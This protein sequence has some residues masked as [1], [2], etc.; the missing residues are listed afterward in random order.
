MGDMSVRTLPFGAAILMLFNTASVNAEE[1]ASIEAKQDDNKEEQQE[2]TS[3]NEDKYNV[4]LSGGYSQERMSE[5]ATDREATYVPISELG[6]NL[7]LGKR[8]D[9][10]FRF[11]SGMTDFPGFTDS[12]SRIDM[13]ALTIKNNGSVGFLSDN[14]NFK[15]GLLGD[16]RVLEASMD[17][18]YSGGRSPILAGQSI[19]NERLQNF[20]GASLSLNIPF[21]KDWSWSFEGTAGR[22]QNGTGQL[23]VSDVINFVANN[24]V[25]AAPVLRRDMHVITDSIFDSLDNSGALDFLEGEDIE[26]NYDVSLPGAGQY[27]AAAVLRD[28]GDSEILDLI[29]DAGID[30]EGLLATELQ[31]AIDNTTITGTVPVQVANDLVHTYLA[32]SRINMH[33]RIDTLSDE[34]IMDEFAS[35]AQYIRALE[36]LLGTYIGGEEFL[37]AI[38]YLGGNIDN[39]D[40]RILGNATHFLRESRGDANRPSVMLKTSFNRNTD[41]SSLSFGV[42]GGRISAGARGT[43]DER[44]VSIFAK[45]S[46]N[47]GS[48][49]K[50]RGSFSAVGYDGYLNLTRDFEKEKSLQTGMATTFGALEWNPKFLDRKLT[51][52][53]GI[54]ASYNYY[55]GIAKHKEIGMQYSILDK[56]KI[57][58]DV[59]GGYGV[60]KYEESYLKPESGKVNAIQAGIL[61]NIKL[62]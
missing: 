42:E 34:R 40:I 36:P 5:P 54:G 47:I 45:G 17:G 35:S 60:S 57:S 8:F 37:G 13:A 50:L 30:V 22:T 55:L 10:D 26:V 11:N 41:R 31:T 28:A 6:V 38:A 39:F 32:Q 25:Y 2:S 48:S 3:S 16:V 15:L 33:A 43:I 53:A 61:F 59:F 12:K 21:T 62:D 44:Y 20:A 52:N 29:I 4:T 49:F 18:F 51:L 7:E 23:G 19:Y 1:V 56:K 9:L 24:N 14:S 46:S 27:L 58:L